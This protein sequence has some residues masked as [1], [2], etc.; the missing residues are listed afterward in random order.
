MENEQDIKEKLIQKI[1]EAQE[2]EYILASML[3]LDL[4][5]IAEQELNK[6]SITKLID[7]IG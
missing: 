7:F 2:A 5:D 1:L 4:I 6:V 3:E